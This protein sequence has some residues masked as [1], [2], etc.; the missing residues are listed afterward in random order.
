MRLIILF[1]TLLFSVN[2]FAIHIELADGAENE[3]CSKLFS[4]RLQKST[5]NFE[6]ATRKLADKGVVPS[7]TQRRL[8]DKNTSHM[9][10]V[11]YSTFDIDN[12]GSN[13]HVYSYFTY[14][15]GQGSRVYAVFDEDLIKTKDDLK[16]HNFRK[17]S[18]I[19][20]V[21]LNFKYSKHGLWFVDL[22]PFEYK[23]EYYI[24]LK[25]IYFGKEPAWYIDRKFVVA[26]YSN[27]M[28]V[29]KHGNKTSK[30]KNICV[31]EYVKANKPIKQ[32]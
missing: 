21:S 13:E 31:F 16:L 29:D 19:N 32:D 11:E 22:Y 30:L 24:G 18:G 26:K 6:S 2:T 27:E 7:W 20:S 10:T 28:F 4:T 1:L 17:K 3:V 15:S 12:D 23:G 9:D 8:T 14:M 5:L 25:D